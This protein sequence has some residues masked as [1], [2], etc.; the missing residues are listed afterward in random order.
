M[1]D[2]DLQFRTDIKELFS[3]FD[4][5]Q[6][7]NIMA[8]A[9]DQQ[10]VYRWIP[11]FHTKLIIHFYLVALKLKLTIG[12]RIILAPLVSK[13]HGCLCLRCAAMGCSTR[14]TSPGLMPGPRWYGGPGTPSHQDPSPST[15]ARSNGKDKSI[16]LV[17]GWLQELPEGLLMQSQLPIAH[18]T[19]LQIFCWGLTCHILVVCTKNLQCEI[20]IFLL[21][22]AIFKILG[23]KEFKNWHTFYCLN[24]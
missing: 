23:I 16:Q 8:L 15:L 21:F 4:K 19:P 12:G 20:I 11:L 24:C 7:H 2:T 9:T 5:M 6:S 1:L 10:P 22:F 14:V 18:W 17:P 3:L 13:D